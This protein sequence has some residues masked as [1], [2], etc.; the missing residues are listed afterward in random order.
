[1]SGRVGWM[2]LAAMVAWSGRM[3]SQ[4]PA[5]LEFDSAAYAWEAGRYIEALGRLERLLTGP[6]R[7]T[8]LAPIALLTGELYRTREIAPDAASPRWSPDGTTLAYEIGS[9]TLRRSVLLNPNDAG[10][11]RPDTLPGYAATF[12]PDGSEIAYLSAGASGVVL[13][14]AAG[15]PER[16]V[17]MPGLAGLALVYGA[18]SGP[19]YLVATADPS[20]QTAELYQLG[21]GAPRPLPGGGRLTGV[22]LRA[23]GGRLVFTSAEFGVTI[24]APNGAT[25]VH[26]GVAPAVSA[27]GS[28]LTFLGRE[29][30]DWTLLHARIGAEP[31]VLVRSP[32]PLAAPTISQDGSL[33]VYQSMPREDW[34]LYAVAAGGGEPRRLTHEIQHDIGPQFVGQRRVLAVMGEGRHRRSYLY[35]ATT[36]T[37]TRLFHNNTVR[38]IAPEYEWA[39]RPDGNV[40]AIVSERDGDTVSPERGLYLTDLRRTVSAEELLARVR[41]SL[42]AERDL[43]QRGTAMFAPIAP[44]VQALVAEVSSARIY[45][46]ERSL[47][48]FGSKHV[49]QPGNKLAIEYLEATL[50]SFGYEPELQWFEPSPGV[51]SANVVATLRGSSDP[52]VQYVVGSHFDS[53]REGPGSDDNTS[54]TAALLEAARV[55]ARR[56]Q[57]ATIRFVWFTSEESGLRGS[58]EFVRLA[59]EAGH[60]VVGGLNNDMVGWANDDRLDNTIRYANRGL[61]DLQ[62]AAAFLFTDL[63][64]YDAHYYKFTDAHSLVDGFGDVISGIGS[65]PVLGN[66]HYHQ[67]HDV[68]E[69]VNHRLVAEVSRTT[70][71]SAVLMASSPSRLAEVTASRAAGGMVEVSWKPAIER[72]VTSYRVRWE[73]AGTGGTGGMRVVRGTSARLAGVP[74]GAAI[75]IRAIGARGV[76]GWDWARVT[77]GE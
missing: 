65:Y 19:P 61:R 22:P 1:M 5:R 18:D 66:P 52:E 35:D 11:L 25:T 28:S 20:A 51:R 75:A 42:R 13:R 6:H 36:S 33:V 60:R 74:A 43:R 64:T 27:D 70:L 14:P 47:F 2:L 69:T 16:T 39:P 29:G 12:A 31:R 24:R 23:A 44:R 53:V 59:R 49:T 62:H 17:E 10:P 54:G 67:P 58:R 72:G 26:R 50:R 40:V 57:A 4:V 21:S 76:E 71:A 7:D 73:D 41:A 37:R 9:D 38:T 56:P 8:L 48:R 63:I 32:R 55:L 68:L 46:Y 34:E 45:D 15:G 3:E 30:A 77:P